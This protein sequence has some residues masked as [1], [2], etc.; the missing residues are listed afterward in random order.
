MTRTRITI[1]NKIFLTYI[2][3]NLDLFL[4]LILKGTYDV[5]VCDSSFKNLHVQYSLLKIFEIINIQYS[6]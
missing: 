3:L 6:C 1:I 2:S 4:D 5:I